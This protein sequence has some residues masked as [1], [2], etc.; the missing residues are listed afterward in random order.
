M[1]P[2]SLRKACCILGIAGATALPAAHGGVGSGPAP[3]Y[4]ATLD[5]T[6][7]GVPHIRAED[8]AGLGYGQGYAVAE[9]NLCVLADAFVTF[10]GERSLHFG[11][12]DRP[13]SPSTF[14]N[15]PNLDAD[16]FFRFVL[17]DARV[18]AFRDRQSG[19]LRQLAQGF[20]A[21]YSR[22]VREI[23][24]GGHAGRHTDCRDAAWLTGID[25]DTVM[26]R[27]LAI[28]MASS[29]S[30]WIGA[31]ATAQPPTDAAAAAVRTEPAAHDLALAVDEA[32][33]AIGR[34]PGLG[35]N[36]LA[37]GAEG[38]GRRSGLS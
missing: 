8:H 5:R 9:D 20:A 36:T 24:G 17:D 15:P 7:Y 29:G 37:F 38:T 23:R 13:G 27:M 35:S 11:P 3:T 19:Q 33:L 32:R 22:Y 31:I 18:A 25:E 16:F 12:D 26:R 2:P 28:N 14:G 34:H 10:R 6:T 30:N 4:R 1:A 21:G